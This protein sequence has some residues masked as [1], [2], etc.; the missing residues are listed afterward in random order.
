MSASYFNARFAR[1]GLTDTAYELFP[2]ENAGQFGQLLADR[3]DLCGVNITIPYKKA[4]LPFLTEMA[5]TVKETGSANLALIRRHPDGVKLS[6]FNTDA[7]GFAACLPTAGIHRNALIL[8][9][10]GAAST[11]A[12]VLRKGGTGVTFVS[13]TTTSGHV[14]TYRHL[15]DH[16]EI[17]ENH[18]L[19][20]NATP[21][22]MFPETAGCPEIP[23]DRL[24]SH[25]FLIDLIYNP[26]RTQFMIRGAAMGAKTMNGMTMFR[27]QAE[28]S[29]AL[30]M[31]K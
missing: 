15:A 11:V 1:E 7:E 29:Y 20:V 6:G 21:A 25:H 3:P 2:L 12:W 17:L 10:G 26:E 13:R 19:V 4:I 14:I 8:G 23:F 18:T 24:S 30:F 27:R 5:E 16:P 9:T 22:G 31:G 28:L